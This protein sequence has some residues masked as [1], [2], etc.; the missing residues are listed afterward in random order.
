M[1]AVTISDVARD[2]GVSK[3]L[4]SLAL[5]DRA[6]VSAATRLRIL[7]AAR[8]LGW[9]PNATARALSTSRTLAYGLVITRDAAVL[10]SDPFFPSFIAGV[11]RAIAPLGHVLVLSVV[12]TEE[13]EAAAFLS[14]IESGRVDG[15][16]LTDLRQ[17]DPRVSLVA[18]LGSR[19][20]IVGRTDDT[21]TFPS[22]TSDD[23]AAVNALADHLVDLG[24]QRIGLVV[25]PTPLLHATRWRT[26]LIDALT[27]RGVPAPSV[28]ETDFSAESGRLATVDLLASPTPPSVIVYANDHMALAGLGAARRRGLEV[29]GD[30]SIV[31]YGNSQMSRYSYPAL[32]SVAV[33]AEEWGYRA[34]LALVECVGGA[35]LDD[36]TLP[37]AQLQVRESTSHAR[38]IRKTEPK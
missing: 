28:I 7:A 8:D 37:P 4:V 26:S 32:T 11:E 25:G 29:P 31:G 16:F 36:L 13:R 33:D 35:D 19:A 1:R 38:P 23:T 14:L 18:D 6:G 17:G 10:G 3:G 22:V 30:L 20:V 5:N 21:T 12:E 2:A 27:D 24:H 9:R 34:A 15:V